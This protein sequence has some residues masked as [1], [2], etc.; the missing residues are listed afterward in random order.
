MQRQWSDLATRRATP[1]KLSLLSLV[2]LVAHW[3]LAAV[4]DHRAAWAPKPCPTFADA[5][6]VVRC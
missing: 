3:R 6:A 4:D 5:L 1:A 2:T